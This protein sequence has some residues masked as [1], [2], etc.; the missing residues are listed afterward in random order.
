NFTDEQFV[1]FQ[2]VGG[3]HVILNSV[4]LVSFT[5]SLESVLRINVMGAKNVL[6]AACKAGARLCHV[7]T[8]YVAGKRDGNIWE[9]E[10]IVGYFPCGDAGN[11]ELLDR[12]FDPAAEIADC[13]KIIDQVRERSNDRQHISKFREKGAET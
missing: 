2:C 13:Q 11:N 8:C 9:D 3:L 5:P 12:D 10:P 1:E 4:G 7:S 6:D